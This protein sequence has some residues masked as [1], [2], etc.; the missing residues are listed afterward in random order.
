MS[1]SWNSLTPDERRR[2]TARMLR[3]YIRV[4]RFAAG[5]YNVVSPK[6][7]ALRER[8]QI[9]YDGEDSVLTATL[10]NQFVNL[11]RNGVRNNATLNGILRQFEVNVV[12]VEGGKASF[13]FGDEYAKAEKTVMDRFA[14]F[15]ESAEFYDGM[16][17]ND[18]LS[19]A[20]KTLLLG[21][22]VAFLFD[23]G[24]IE[25]CGRICAFEPDCIANLAPEKFEARFPG[26]TQSNGRIRNANGRWFGVIVSHALRGRTEFDD[27]DKCYILNSPPDVR[28][29][30]R[31]WTYVTLRYRFN[32]G[33][34]KSPLTAGLGPLIDVEMLQG[35][36]VES[37]KKNAQT[38]AQLVETAHRPPPDPALGDPSQEG[39]AT[40]FDEN[41]T[42]EQ[43]AAAAAEEA[44]NDELEEPP[45]TFDEM[46]AAGCVYE[47]MP[48]NAKLELLD[49]KHPNPNMNEF[50]RL[51][52][53]RGGWSLGISS[54][55]TTGK[56]ESSYTGFRGEQ[57][58]SWQVFRKWQKLLEREICDWALA[59]WAAWAEAR[60][61][62]ADVALPDGW[63]RRVKWFW[64]KMPEVNPVDAQNARNLGLKN[65]SLTYEDDLGPGWKETMRK[66]ARERGFMKSL[67]LPHPADETASGQRVG[68]DAGGAENGQKTIGG[69][70]A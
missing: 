41:S 68:T 15:C 70:N 55:Y 22:G 24:A 63:R 49:T 12:G 1:K 11:A 52:A 33:G 23:G 50:I 5:R 66:A 36:E 30:D 51:V 39:G 44:E 32:Q 61:L 54:V 25:G 67:G 29:A 13:D 19:I 2:A 38:L 40:V 10:R 46:H 20:L 43:L 7:T 53:C 62:L 58:M 26:C 17:L 56:V 57:V 4:G 16:N 35:F 69:E 28:P 42:D 18:V 34:G 64:P 14:D 27:P 3:T 45:V 21:G 47:V 48:E 37:A 31:D 65:F 59:R 6:Y 60:G 8:P 9:E